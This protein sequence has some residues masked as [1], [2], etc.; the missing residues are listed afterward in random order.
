MT[1][2]GLFAAG[3][4][5]DGGAVPLGHGGLG[6]LRVR[7]GSRG[8][9]DALEVPDQE[10]R[11]GHDGGDGGGSGEAVQ[12]EEPHRLALLAAGGHEALHA[13]GRE[14]MLV[15]GEFVDS[16][17]HGAGAGAQ[18]LDL[19]PAGGAVDKMGADGRLVLRR[20]I[21]INKVEKPGME[22]FA[23]H[24]GLSDLPHLV[25]QGRPGVQSAQSGPRP[26]RASSLP[27]F[28]SA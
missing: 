5:Q 22:F 2:I 14:V 28:L 7:L 13:V 16:G 9:E 26:T 24:C 12:G 15:G 17:P 20:H 10:R 3:R 27:I 18:L 23:V 4:G 25:P 21:A 1:L 8:I 6:H 11:S 19:R